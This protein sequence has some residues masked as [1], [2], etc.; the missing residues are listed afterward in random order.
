[1]NKSG[2]PKITFGIIVLNGEPFTRYCLRSLY[3]FAHEIIVVEGGHEDAKSVCTPDGHSIDGTLEAL[4]KFKKEED[5]ENK[6]T[7]VTR[8][9]FWPKKDELG[10]NRTPQSRAYAE[11]ATG[12]Y[13]WQIDIDEFYEEEDMKRILEML[14]RD[15]SITAVTFP[16][17]TFWGDIHY[18]S[19]SWALRRG[20]KYYHRLF[21]WSKAYKY[22][23]HEPPTVVDET[24]TDLRKKNWVTGRVMKR[25][26]IYMYHY[27]LLFPWQVEQKVRVYNDEHDNYK[28]IVDWA[29]NNYFKLNNPYRVHN[30]FRLPSW[31]MRHKGKHP[32]QIKKMMQDIKEGKLNVKVRKNED[33]EVLLNSFNYKLKSFF[34]ASLE[35]IDFW[36]QKFIF[37]AGRVKNIPGKIKRITRSSVSK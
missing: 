3:P 37:N 1:M 12:D 24:G 11:R 10:R 33:V 25:K 30:I 18:E 23:T 36:W 26:N 2:F 7:I 22:L 4:H 31:L 27:S 6:V 14:K 28:G 15:P 13:L 34:L 21:K 35:P 9:G 29:E 17:Y 20:A 32:A 16:T 8:D 5:H 19:D